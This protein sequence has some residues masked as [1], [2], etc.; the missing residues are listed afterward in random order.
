MKKTSIWLALGK[1]TFG[2][3]WLATVIPGSCI[4]THNIAAY[5]T[6]NSLG[7]S[8]VLIAT[9]LFS[10]CAQL[11]TVKNVE[12]LPP[13]EGTTSAGNVS[14]EGEA[15]R[16]PEAA[17]SRDLDICSKAW[18]DLKR[19]PADSGARQLYNYSVARIVSLLQATGKLER[20]GS[21]TIGTGA[22]AYKLTFASDIKA[23]AD[24]RNCHFVP[25]DELAI[26]G[27][28]YQQ[29]VRRD[30]IGAPVL[31]EL[32]TPL[33]NARERFLIS[34]RIFYSMTAVLEFQGAQARLIMKD[35]LASGT[36]SIAGRSYPL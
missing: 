16:D 19:N 5:W 2:R 33:K 10:A 34:D 32:D 13:A 9:F 14:T 30:G 27:K 15:R 12:P 26:S 24:P 17:L 3:P 28:D 29:R 23:F 31:A 36:V 18:S 1:P 7:A 25:A 4:A 22:N 8:M 21:V 35:P 20:A 11:A 6:L